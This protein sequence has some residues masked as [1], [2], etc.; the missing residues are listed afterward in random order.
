MRKT[1][2]PILGDAP[3]G[4][5][6]CQFYQDKKDLLDLLVPYFKAGLENNEYCLWICSEPLGAEEAKK[7]FRTAVP[8]LSAY[9]EKGAIEF[10]S[11]SQWYLCDGR[12]RPET[13]LQGWKDKLETAAAR[14]FEGLRVSSNTSWLEKKDWVDFDAYERT[15]NTVI[16]DYPIIAMCAYSLERCGVQEVIDVVQNHQSTLIR[17]AGKWTLVASTVR[18]RFEENLIKSEER[19]R[20]AQDSARV[21]VWDRSLPSGELYFSPQFERLYGVAPGS[22]R[23]YEDLSRMIHPDDLARVEAERDRAIAAG[24]PLDLEFR[25]LHGSGEVRWFQAKGGSIRDKEGNVL[26]VFGVSIDVTDR[27]R[28][29]EALAKS[30][31]ELELRVQERTRDLTAAVEKAKRESKERRRAE[32][33]LSATSRILEG[34][35]ASTIFPMAI[36]DKDLNFVR[37]NDSY[38]RS[39]Q[40]PA[41]DFPGKNHFEMF[42]D[43]DNEAIF[44]NVVESK[45]PFQ[46]I[47]KRF[48]F[49]DHPEWAVSYWD[50]NLSPVLD[51]SGNVE[52]LVFSLEDV[53]VK[54]TAVEQLRRNEETLRNIFN[55]APIGIWVLDRD[56]KI[57]D[58][59]PGIR[60]IWGDVR[61]VG[62]DGYREYKAW[63]PDTGERYEPDEWGGARAFKKGET[64]LDQ[65]AEIESFD[66]TRKMILASAAPVLDG[67]GRLSGAICINQDITERIRTEKALSEQAALLDLAHDAIL[68]CALDGTILSWTHGAET[69][70]GWTKGEALGKK[71]QELLRS[72]F[73]EPLDRIVEKVIRTGRWEGEIVQTNRRGEKLITSGRWALKVDEKGRPAGILKI[74]IDVTESKKGEQALLASSRYTRRLIEASLDP[75]VT[76]SPEGKVTDVNRATELVTGYSRE[77]LIGS[78]FSDF[79][80]EP[81]NARRAYLTA[82]SRGEVRDYPLAIRNAQ[83]GVTEVVYNASVYENEAGEV[84]GV[85]AAARDITERKKAEEEKLRLAKALEQTAEGIVILDI[86]QEIT[87]VNAAFEKISGLRAQDVLRSTYGEILRAAGI[88]GGLE[89]KIKDALDRRE[90][91]IGHMIRH[92]TGVGPY[93]V[94]A[95]ISPVFD[96]AG[97]L[98]NFVAIERDVTD[99]VRLQERI[100]QGQKMEALGTL[101]GGIAHDFNN[102]LMPILINTEMSVLDEPEGTPNAKR[103]K[104]VLEAANRGKDLVKQIISFSR[105]K[106]QEKT[107]IRV[108]PVLKEGL[109]FLRASIPKNIEIVD[110]IEAGAA[111]VLADATQIHQVLINLCSNAAYAMRDKGGILTVRFS[112]IEVGPARAVKH[113]DLKPGPYLELVVRDTGHGM[114]P[115][116]RLKAFDPFFTTKAP[117][118]GSGLGLAVV[119]GIVKDL[120]GAIDVESEIGKGSTFAI[121]LPALE[122]G[123]VVEA[124]AP[125]THLPTGTG[126]ILFVDD[127]EIHVHSVPP[128]LERLGYQVVGR[129]DAKAALDLFRERPDAFD[130][131]ITD[132]MMPSMTGE[133]LARE[134]R[135]VRPDLPII[136]CTGFSETINEERAKAQ[137]IGAFLMK[138]FSIKEIAEAIR[139]VLKPTS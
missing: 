71:S 3:W 18:K 58:A 121:F 56:G 67:E 31:A 82:F 123:P 1:G 107:R 73:P 45:K 86:D 122:S 104:L 59:N 112:K 62:F 91:W 100:K 120:G 63:H 138:P 98:K 39:N 68:V 17:R 38:A 40:R 34:F 83:G 75:L 44:R 74:D 57:T 10:L 24:E 42:P 113:L 111:V 97:A 6:F 60:K 12:F 80:T 32:K 105:R 46:A 125:A 134:M 94:D 27:K 136:L 5:H 102:I 43:A 41:S 15:F 127:E 65:E 8:D 61:Y 20:L 92:K 16:Y 9:L 116:V 93:E 99:E 124:K 87:Y 14:G 77:E 72:E 85:F 76:I 13:V 11:G 126:R 53:T 64:V 132:Q 106:A 101:A 109:K 33:A 49:P 54:T 4:T 115:E 66:G 22:L 88:E 29:E 36:L 55:T 50:W 26:R 119:H 35:F 2:I 19:L 95:A 110:E 137:G 28:I 69:L 131:V 25:V 21:G 114:T 139:R 135:R 130:A 81:S 108:G 117:G 133:T 78:D 118:E 52:F 129:T 48:V 96:E 90:R 23:T 47:A 79:F 103:M 128:I 30:R 89:S 70:F 51:R 7:A 84:Q 37:V